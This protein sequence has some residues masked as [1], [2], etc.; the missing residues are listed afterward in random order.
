VEPDSRYDVLIADLR[1]LGRSAPTL[2]RDPARPDPATTELT[3]AVMA[4]LADA[5]PPR[6]AGRWQRLGQQAIASARRRR[7]QLMIATA[8][9]L[10]GCLGVPGVRAAVIDWFTF[11][12]VNV[13]IQ[14]TPSPSVTQAPPPP[15]VHGTVSMER[16]RTL[17]EFQPVMLTALGPAQ[18]I[19][20]SADRRL[21][22]LTWN[23]QNG[24]TTR[25]DQFDGKL[26][27]VF[28]KTAPDVEWTS[29]G[30][31]SAM[32][33]DKPHEVVILDAA[34]NR[35]TE[36]ARLAGH[37]LIWEYAGTVLR[38]EGDFSLERAVEIAGSAQPLP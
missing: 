27:Y 8:V 18:G 9:V 26:D 16:A 23:G 33:F 29:V 11:D 31:T 32:W 20:V 15:T 25:L 12:G 35:R 7:R 2:D 36:T 21:L 14:P 17:V 28:F 30:G 6:P 4:R 1:T 19:E 10:L 5:P 38:L 3:T 34:G 37:T 22:S 24:A 13:R